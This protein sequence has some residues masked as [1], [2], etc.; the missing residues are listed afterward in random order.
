ML[1]K[2]A[3]GFY[4]RFIAKRFFTKD[5]KLTH[6]AKHMA[7][8]DHLKIYAEDILTLNEGV[9]SKKVQ[10]HVYTP[11]FIPVRVALFLIFWGNRWYPYIHTY[12]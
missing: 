2:K 8:L 11:V 5:H 3:S 1:G 7:Q 9:T 4:E 12:T 10:S 6:A